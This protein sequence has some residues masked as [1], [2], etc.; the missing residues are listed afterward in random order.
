MVGGSSSG[1]CVLVVSG[2]LSFISSSLIYL[3]N[4]HVLSW[5]SPLYAVSLANSFL[6]SSWDCSGPL[7][8]GASRHMGVISGSRCQCLE[9]GNHVSL[10]GHGSHWASLHPLQAFA[11]GTC[12]WAG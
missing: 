6:P 12:L 3:K 10:R 1:C 7:L 2:P 9:S 11:A 5:F 8:P 4:M